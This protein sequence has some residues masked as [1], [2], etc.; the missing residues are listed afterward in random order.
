MKYQYF[1]FGQDHRHVIAG[2]VFDANC[3]VKIQNDDGGARKKMF[4][5]F[6]P[7]WCAQYTELPDMT[8][9][10]RGVIEL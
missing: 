8:F 3:L 4:E 5:L 6:G 9:F 10:P 2:T 7:K 1:S